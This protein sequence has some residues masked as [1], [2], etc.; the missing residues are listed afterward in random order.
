MSPS[1]PWIAEAAMGP[2]LCRS[3]EGSHSGWVQ[4]P[5]YPQKTTYSTPP[6]PLTLYLLSFLASRCSL[7]LGG[8]DIDVSSRDEQSL[9]RFFSTFTH[10]ESALVTA[11]FKPKLPRS[12]LRAAP[13]Y[14]YN[15]KHSEGLT[16]CT[17]S[18]T[19]VVAP[20]QAYHVGFC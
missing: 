18:K 1:P 4:Q 3:Y 20:T 7:D 6:H 2:A 9:V 13:I 10:Y 5:R 14:G 15:H 12:R 11:C 19:A 17:Y 16:S 8:G